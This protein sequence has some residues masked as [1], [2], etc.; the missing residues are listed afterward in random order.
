MADK[1]KDL[2]ANDGIR[3]EILE[4]VRAIALPDC[5]IAAGCIR[6]LV[7]DALHGIK[8]PLN[9]IDVVYFDPLE[10]DNQ[11]AKK[12]SAQLNKQY[13]H[14]NWQVKNQAFMHLRN[15]DS[16]YKNTLDAMSYWPEQETAVA[17]ALLDDGSIRIINSFALDS[18]YAGKITHN[19]KRLRT[20]FIHRI[21]AKNWL[22]VWPKLQ[23]VG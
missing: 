22:G 5:Y 10:E 11:Q 12:I 6:N 15:G 2:L 17:A 9:D 20:V 3:M 7:W 1:L 23:V 16:P 14:L 4:I 8:T 21:E 18:L 19:K 13:P